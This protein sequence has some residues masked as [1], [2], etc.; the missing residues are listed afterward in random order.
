[1]KARQKITA[2][3]LNDETIRLL[4]LCAQ[5]RAEQIYTLVGFVVSSTL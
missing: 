2:S 1:M 4:N 5:R 3:G